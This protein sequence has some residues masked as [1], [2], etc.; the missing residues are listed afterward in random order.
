MSPNTRVNVGV[1]AQRP[2]VIIVMTGKNETIFRDKNLCKRT[3]TD[4]D[5]VLYSYNVVLYGV[6]YEP[7]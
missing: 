5:T 7:K 3:D 1:A 6:Q 2:K 4:T